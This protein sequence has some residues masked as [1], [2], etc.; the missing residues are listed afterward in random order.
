MGVPVKVVRA[1]LPGGLIVW[2]GLVACAVAGPISGDEPSGWRQNGKKKGVSTSICYGGD[3]DA[4][5]IAV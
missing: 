5:K 3:D 4:S 1:S 2:R